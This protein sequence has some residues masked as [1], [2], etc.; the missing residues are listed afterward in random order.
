M[1]W[2][3]LLLRSGRLPLLVRNH[4]CTYWK[5]KMIIALNLLQV[6]KFACYHCFHPC[7]LM[8]ILNHK[9]RFSSNRTVIIICLNFFQACAL[10]FGLP[11]LGKLSLFL[12]F[13]AIDTIV[14]K[15]IVYNVILILV[16]YSISK[17]F[18]QENCPIF[19]S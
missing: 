5:S 6:E 2:E 1:K 19:S 18:Y 3:N 14:N 17:Y 10:W 13:A 4:A 11:L 8:V 9:T 12:G 7:F 15:S 16:E